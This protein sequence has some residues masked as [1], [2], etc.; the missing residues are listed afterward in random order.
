ML[1]DIARRQPLEGETAV[2]FGVL[3]AVAAW[4]GAAELRIGTA[5]HRRLLTILLLHNTERVGRARIIEAMWPAG[6]PRSADNLVQKYVGELRRAVD[7]TGELVISAHGGYRIRVDPTLVDAQ[8]FGQLL[9]RAKRARRRG[10]SGRA[11]EELAAALALWRGEPF[12]GVD[13]DLAVTARARLSEQRIA[14]MED[15]AEL[16]LSDGGHDAA[17]AELALLTASH[18]LRERAR[19]LHMLALYRQGRQAEALTVYAQVRRLLAD[20]LGIDPDPSLRQLYE[21]ILRA[22]PALGRPLALVLGPAAAPPP[23]SQL[24]SDLADF[25]GRAD[26]IDVLVAALS[27]GTPDR[28]P[29]VISIVGS[30]GVG[31]SSLAVHIAHAVRASYPDGQLYLELAGTSEGP[32]EPADVLAEVLRALEITGAA[33]PETLHERAGLYRSLLADRRMLIVLDD[34]AHAGQVRHLLPATGGCAVV[35]TSRNLL[36]DLPSTQHVNLDVFTP[37]EA[38]NLLAATIG[39]ERVAREPEQATAILASCGYL[40]LAIRIAGAKLVGRRAWSL[41]VLRERLDERRRLDE[42]R[43]GELGVRASFDLSMRQLPAAAARALCLLALQGPQTWPG[44]VVAPLLDQHDTDDV[45]D[46][47]VDASL[48]RLVGTDDVGQPR[49]RLHDLLRAYAGEAAETIPLAE[50]TQAIGRLL[51]AWLELLDKAVDRLPPSLFR[52]KPGPSPRLPLPAAS[53]RR[54]LADPRAWLDAE[55]EGLLNAVRLATEWSMDEPAWELASTAVPYYDMHCRYEE[56]RRGHWLA[57]RAV[58]VAGNRRG[59]ATLLRGLGQ[60]N[61]YRDVYDLATADFTESWRLS[62]EIGDRHGAAM[63]IAGQ[64]TVARVLDRHEEALARALQALEMVVGEGDAH[65][66]AQLRNSVAGIHLA[67]GREDEAEAWYRDALAIASRL[68]DTHREA[69]VLRHMSTL[70]T[71]RGDAAQALSCL[72]AA[73]RTFTELGD[74]RCGGYALLE[75]GRLF[76]AQRDRVRGRSA[77]A[78][79]ADLFG[80]NG[81][82]WNEA[83]CWQLLGQ[84]DAGNGDDTHAREYL[85]RARNLWRSVGATTRADGT[86]KILSALAG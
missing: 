42:L 65:I 30:P 31:K 10:E 40:P 35:V 46:L 70:H 76:V 37:D 59:E 20:E 58:R 82:R 64:A 19:A 6:P 81:D 51:A 49:Y 57:L 33:V 15:L 54:L 34:V 84:L 36:S 78:R 5:K 77:L 73:L 1:A 12:E 39:A 17:A 28:P 60:L 48:V 29:A 7:P 71:R 38:R 43:I 2:R 52:P 45:L 74:E 79:A 69:V 83:E 61:V 75:L 86:T 8:L 9:D 55:R 67:M 27:P 62:V 21:Q 18:P 80:R 25:V 22:D 66:E 3:G 4:R 13:I 72:R 47:L 63:G 85:L 11:A 68:G 53:T 44:W 50:R 23:V 56:W 14:A 32:R 16:R 26:H 41:R 24:P